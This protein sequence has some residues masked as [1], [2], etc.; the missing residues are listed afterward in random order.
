[1]QGT[2]KQA[3]FGRG[4]SVFSPAPKSSPES[5][6]AAYG[7]HFWILRKLSLNYF[8]GYFCGRG[9]GS[10][11]SYST[12]LPSFCPSGR[13]QTSCYCHAKLVR[14]QHDS[15]TTWFQTSKLIQ[16]NRTDLPKTKRKNKE[17]IQPAFK[18][19]L[20]F[21]NLLIIIKFGTAVAR[22]GFKPR[23]T[24][25]LKSNLIRSI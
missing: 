25:V 9:G 22:L 12:L 1:M 11:T 20:M 17:T 18:C 4:P 14:L 3:L 6:L 24:A 23:A 16:S 13:F 10:N 2:Y 21:H 7:C 5:L 19:I 8:D 15:S